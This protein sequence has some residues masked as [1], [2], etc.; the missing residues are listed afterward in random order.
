[1]LPPITLIVAMSNE[2]LALLCA[3]HLINPRS[4]RLTAYKQYSC[5]LDLVAFIAPCGCLLTS[6]VHYVRS[7]FLLN[8]SSPPLCSVTHTIVHCDTL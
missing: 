4:N 1:M 7:E 8:T 2:A 5:T 6:R 3:P